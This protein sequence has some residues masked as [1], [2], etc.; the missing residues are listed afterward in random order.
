MPTRSPRQNG[1]PENKGLLIRFLIILLVS[2]FSALG[3]SSMTDRS[4]L[5]K[6]VEA[7]INMAGAAGIGLTAG[8]FTRILLANRR[9]FLRG[10]VSLAGVICGL[11]V[12]GGMTDWEYGIG[13][14][15]FFRTTTDWLGLGLIILGSISAL[16]A[17]LAFHKPDQTQ[18]A[19]GRSSSS[20]TQP[21]ARAT[22]A[23]V[24]STATH[25]REVPA[26]S[27][28]TSWR[29]GGQNRKNAVIKP[30]KRS[31]KKKKPAG[32][33]Q[34]KARSTPAVIKKRTSKKIVIA[35][36]EEHRC[37]YCLEPVKRNDPRGV[38]EC[39]ICHTLHH[40][41]CWAITGTCQVPHYNH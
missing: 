29:I 20:N 10:I 35:P 21:A 24:G 14:L 1:S 25:T 34:Q 2:A 26:V 7:I 8:F 17:G 19:A 27:R 13:P 38:V 9:A 37:P 16:I 33:V 18:S 5:F 23:S 11:L 28:T 31:A 3:F 30:K 32:S 6:G 15:Y 36:V 41:D 12:L 39:S 22:S 40:A 4:E